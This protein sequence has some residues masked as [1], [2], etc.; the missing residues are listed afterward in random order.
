MYIKQRVFIIH[1]W[2]GRADGDWLPWLQAELQKR[3]YDAHILSMP[4]PDAPVMAEWL[5]HMKTSIGSPE[6]SDIFVGHSMGCL[7]I[8]KYLQ[9]QD[10]PVDKVLLVAGWEVLSDAALTE[11]ADH[12][13]VNSW[14][15]DLLDYEKLRTL[16]HKFIAY[17]SDN[18]PWVPLEPNVQ[19]YREKLGAEIIIEHNKGHF[20][21]EVGGISEMPELL[22]HLK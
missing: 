10:E 21:K 17:F 2:T 13:I 18:D 12:V 14:T 19:I 4:T 16:V 3:S 20:M 22:T 7:A 15:R 1:G 11:P 8:L 5:E 9:E 6:T